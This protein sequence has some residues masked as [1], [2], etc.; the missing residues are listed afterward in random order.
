MEAQGSAC[1]CSV[2]QIE[3]MPPSASPSRALPAATC[4]RG[5]TKA[6]EKHDEEYIATSRGNH[7]KAGEEAP[8][9]CLGVVFFRGARSETSPP[10]GHC[11]PSASFT[12]WVVYF[13]CIFIAN[14]G[15]FCGAFLE[16][17]FEGAREAGLKCPRLSP[18]LEAPRKAWRQPNI[19]ARPV[20]A[21]T[22]PPQPCARMGV[23]AL[24]GVLGAN[25]QAV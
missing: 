20:L 24:K 4:H 14:G 23:Q 17:R 11:L 8:T 10:V 25:F 3:E 7:P 19:P 5:M 21:P 15:A 18:R 16:H 9:A 6:Y 1:A 2:R 13:L 12:H 22:R